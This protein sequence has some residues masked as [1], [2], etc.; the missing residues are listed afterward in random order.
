V[1]ASLPF[2]H[3]RLKKGPSRIVIVFSQDMIH[4]GSSNAAN[5]TANYLLVENGQNNHFDTTSCQ[6][7]RSG[8]DLAVN[9]FSV[10]YGSVMEHGHPAFIATLQLNPALPS[11]DYRLFVCGSTSIE[12]LAGIKLN[13]GVDTIISF[14]V[15]GNRHNH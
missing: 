14:S 8:D 13:N 2:D 6:A 3:S 10:Q 12:N 1:I 15:T 4:D 5:N 7:G 9:I 11:G